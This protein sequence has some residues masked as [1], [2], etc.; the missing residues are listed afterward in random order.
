MDR[1][2]RILD[3]AENLTQARGFNGFS[4]LHVAS[5][6]EIRTS[7]VHYHFKTKAELALALVDRVHAVHFE[8]FRGLNSTLSSPKKRIEALVRHFEG[9]VTEGKFCLCGMM[10]A[11]LQSVSPAVQARVQDYFDQ[12]QEWVATQFRELGHPQS[13]A[14]KRALTFVSALEGSLLLAR[15]T[16]NPK[17]V[18]QALAVLTE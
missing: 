7:S 17:L 9:Y 14:R 16:N 5:E 13:S 11:E 15:L 18:R 6:L 1:K 2:T 4:Y 12:L 8:A 10:A 3:A